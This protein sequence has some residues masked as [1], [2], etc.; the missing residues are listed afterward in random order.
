MTTSKV[1]A[2]PFPISA[3]VA[4]GFEHS[5]A[6]CGDLTWTAAALNNLEAAGRA[7]EETA[8]LVR[9]RAELFERTIGALRQPA[10]LARAAAG[11]ER[12]SR[13]A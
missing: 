13:D 12:R 5:A 7:L 10:D 8:R 2:V 1:V 4:A 11:L 6:D 9:T 3:F